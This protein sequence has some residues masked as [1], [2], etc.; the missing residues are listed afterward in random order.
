[1]KDGTWYRVATKEEDL[2]KATQKAHEL[3]YEITVKGDNNLPQNSRSFSSVAKSIVKRLE[4]TKGTSQWKQTYQS[5]IYAINKYQIPHFK[6][7]KLDRLRE[8]YEG[9]I[10]FVAK[11]IGKTPKQ[12]T[13]NNHHAALR[14]IMDEAIERGW[15]NSST[16][17]VIKSKGRQSERRPTFEISEYRSLIK[18]LLHWSKKPTHRKKDAEI[19][20]MLYD[21]VLFLANSG[22]RHGRE[23]M[24]ITWRNV[25]FGKSSKKNDIITINV[26]KRK[27]RKGTEERREVVVRHNDFS[28]FK[29]VLTRI[30]DRNPKLAKKSLETL[31]KQRID[32]PLFVLSDGTQ[33]KRMDGTFKKF[34]KDADLLIGAE[35]KE[36]TLYSFRHFYATQQ[37]LREPP[38]TIYLLAKQLGTSVKMIEHHY[39]HLETFQK[40]DRLSGWKEID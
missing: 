35:E 7:S 17:P 39:G 21:Y 27:G 15:A 28:D 18:K 3:Y 32:E 25:S 10:D 19:R 36:R 14:L 33:P 2:E 12:S 6:H 1:M 29:K 40:A 11:E 26:V 38:I 16:L 13:L 20:I 8:K 37:L 9:Y 31:I 5:Y 22:V 23:A 24:D 34:L 4:D 30:K